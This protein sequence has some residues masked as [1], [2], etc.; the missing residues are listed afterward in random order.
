MSMEFRKIRRV[1]IEIN[2]Q[3]ED[4]SKNIVREG[5]QLADH[6]LN[7]AIDKGDFIFV[8]FHS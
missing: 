1:T 6:L 7:Y 8:S 3:Q 2:K 5:N 4:T